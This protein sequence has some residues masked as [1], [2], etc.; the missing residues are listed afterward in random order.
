MAVDNYARLLAMRNILD[1]DIIN[2]ES[3]AINKAY[4][5]NYINN[6]YVKRFDRTLL[7]TVDIH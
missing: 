6:T 5:A 7:L 4:S 3:T 1:N 2:E